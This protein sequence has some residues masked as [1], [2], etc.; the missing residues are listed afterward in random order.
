MTHELRKL[1]NF[2]LFSEKVFIF[3]IQ[4]LLFSFCENVG[5]N[6]EPQKLRFHRYG[7]K[8]QIGRSGV[9]FLIGRL[10][11][12]NVKYIVS[13]YYLCM[14]LLFYYVIYLQRSTFL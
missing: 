7:Q 5:Y 11:V 10:G 1:I 12:K 8:R 9:T 4:Y 3:F 13:E 6:S 14:I 2:W